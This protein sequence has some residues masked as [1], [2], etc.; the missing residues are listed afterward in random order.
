MTE[1]TR[2]DLVCVNPNWSAFV[3]M[4]TFLLIINSL[5]VLLPLPD[6]AK[7]VLRTVNLAI[8]VVLWADFIYLLRKSPVKRTFMV[9]QH[10]WMV[11][12]GSIPMLRF[13]R[14]IWFH[15]TLKKS[16]YTLRDFLAGIVVKQDA[17]GTLLSVLFVA[18]VLFEVAVVA[19]LSFEE[20]A[21]GS[22]IT[23]ISDAFWWASTTVTTG[24]FGDK[25]PVSQGGRLIAVLLMILGLA[26]FSVITGSLA[27]WFRGRQLQP[28]LERGGEAPATATAVAEIKHLLEQQMELHQQTVAELKGRIIELEQ[29]LEQ[30][31]KG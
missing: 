9:G 12:L 21:P 18:I 14:I 6:D 2:D 4:V 5:A 30:P 27:E 29:R 25:Y 17:G 1:S 8:S 13:L 28:A 22:N 7:I 19:I 3:L 20:T 11:L 23:S 26:L 31:K 10:G 15:L 16:D 24:G